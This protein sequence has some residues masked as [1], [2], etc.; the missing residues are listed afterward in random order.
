MPC[1]KFNSMETF[2]QNSS[3]YDHISI[4]KSHGFVLAEIDNRERL[5]KLLIF[6]TP[7]AQGIMA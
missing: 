5:V 3:I 7:L 4:D 1:V 6:H 2:N